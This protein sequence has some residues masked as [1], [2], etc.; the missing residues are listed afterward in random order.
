MSL[1]TIPG[2]EYYTIPTL[3]TKTMKNIDEISID[4]SDI[5]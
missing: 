3:K 5:D 4:R 2:A 1:I